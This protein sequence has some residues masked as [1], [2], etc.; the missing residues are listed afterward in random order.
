MSGEEQQAIRG[1]LPFDWGW[2]Q[3]DVQKLFAKLHRVAVGNAAV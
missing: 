1:F 3:H 2:L